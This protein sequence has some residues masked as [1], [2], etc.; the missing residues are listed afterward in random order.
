V[1]ILHGIKR[2]IARLSGPSTPV[3]GGGSAAAGLDLGQ[4]KAVQR[5]EFEADEHQDEE[6]D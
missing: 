3:V 1:G 2:A 6:S 4:I 5:E